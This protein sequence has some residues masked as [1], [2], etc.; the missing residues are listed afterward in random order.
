M[1]YTQPLYTQILYTIYLQT[2]VGQTVVGEF[3]SRFLQQ[4]RANIVP[5]ITLTCYLAALLMLV[6]LV[7]MFQ[8]GEAQFNSHFYRWGMG[9][10]FITI[11]PNILSTILLRKGVN[12]VVMSAPIE[13]VKTEGSG[14]VDDAKIE[15]L[16]NKGENE[17]NTPKLPSTGSE[18]DGTVNNPNADPE[19]FGMDIEP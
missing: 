11:F 18:L 4:E 8:R 7:R 10:V 1:L 2:V 12:D 9:I 6:K 13:P 16:I 15:D 14:Y 3:T 5:L 19:D 17:K